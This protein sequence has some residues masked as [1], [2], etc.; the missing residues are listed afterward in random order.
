[1]LLDS[2][3]YDSEATWKEHKAQTKNN[4]VSKHIYDRIFLSI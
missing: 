3:I 2:I 4:P 1:M